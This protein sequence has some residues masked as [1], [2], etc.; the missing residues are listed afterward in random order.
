MWHHLRTAPYFPVRQCYEDWG[1]IENWNKC[2]EDWVPK[3]ILLSKLYKFTFGTFIFSDIICV[4][5]HKNCF[6]CV[7]FGIGITNRTG[8]KE[9]DRLRF[10]GFK[11]SSFYSL[12]ICIKNHSC[13]NSIVSYNSG[14]GVTVKS[15]MIFFCRC[16]LE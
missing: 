6:V 14:G 10:Q 1:S 12:K 3:N 7:F 16:C 4:T 2:Y 15:T 9:H 13:W 8:M 5:Y 11:A